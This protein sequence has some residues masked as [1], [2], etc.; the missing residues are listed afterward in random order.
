[1]DNNPLKQALD[2]AAEI[3]QYAFDNA[4]KPTSAKKDAEILAELDAIE[5]RI[6]EFEKIN[7][8]FVE[9]SELTPFTLETMM[10]DTDNEQIT[11]EQRQLLLRAEELKN[12]AQAASKNLQKAAE[13]ARQ[14]DTK[15]TEKPKKPEKGQKSR[16]GKFRS[17]GGV[18]NWKPL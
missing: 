15:L 12:H 14:S 3:L 17:M 7:K 11:E 10:M 8:E 2:K 16:K 18:K 9:A 5:Q 4:N 1:M 6:K 13:V